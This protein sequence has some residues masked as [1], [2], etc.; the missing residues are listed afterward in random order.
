[1]ATRRYCRLGLAA[2]VILATALGLVIAQARL[3]QAE[4]ECIGPDRVALVARENG[5]ATHDYRGDAAVRWLARWNAEPP[6][7]ALTGDQVI[8]LTRQAGQTALVFVLAGGC[9]TVWWEEAQ[10]L[11]DEIATAIAG[12]ET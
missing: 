1:M 6:A 2:V 4:E 8:V 10:S 3:V 12:V 5:A 7:T 9:L 11:V